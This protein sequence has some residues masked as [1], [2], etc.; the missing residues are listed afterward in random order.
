MARKTDNLVPLPEYPRPLLA[1]DEWV[2]LNGRWRFDYD[3]D[4]SGEDAG[5]HETGDL[6]RSIMVP[7]VHQAPLSG[8]GDPAQVDYVWYAREF[9]VLSSWL[10]DRLV[11]N[12][13]AVDYEATV[14]VNGQ[15]V[16]EHRGGFTPFSCDITAACRPG[17]G[18]LLVVRAFDPITPE[19]PSG[20]QSERESY[21]CM[22]TRSTGIWQTV[23][24]EPLGE[25][26]V[27]VPRI[28]TSLKGAH[29][30]LRVPVTGSAENVYVRVNVQSGGSMLATPEVQPRDGFAEFDI[31]I[32]DPVPWN[33]ETAHLYD[34]RIVTRRGQV[35]TDRASSYFGMRE[36]EVSGD[37][38]L[39][40]GEP[41]VFRGI[42]DQGL[43]P[44]GIYTAPSDLEMRNEISRSLQ[45]GFN[46]ARLHQ[47]VFDPRQLYWAD[48]MGYPVWAE[49]PDWGCHLANPAA[50][51]NLMRE[52][53][54]AVSRDI[55]HP[56]IIIWTPLNE[57]TGESYHSDPVQHDFVR[58]LVRRTKELDSTR[59]VCSTSGYE[60]VTETDIADTHDYRHDPEAL[61]KT[62]TPPFGESGPVTG[63]NHPTFT[64][65]ERYTG[66]PVIVSEMGGMWWDPE[67]AAD[68]EAWGYGD[69]PKSVEDF[70]RIYK[71]IIQVCLECPALSG[72][73]Y[74]QL[75]DVEQ[76]V[77]GLYTYD[78]KPKFDHDA[79]AAIT[80]MP[81]EPKPGG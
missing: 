81:V 12:F 39:L 23:W 34:M 35:V 3:P 9:A 60:H 18:N 58:E 25:A 64:Q 28:I 79:I 33:M 67:K 74:T 55:S 54:E 76:E 1:R 73:V 2:N 5:W 4:G 65:G 47:K 36:V 15:K 70:I 44:D 53:L 51:E 77:N 26:F 22:Y 56:S 57:R 68:T 13:G 29:V 80:R 6:K 50:R 63:H 21:G 43:W 30:K 48:R 27:G 37:R 19:H 66:Q 42:L 40:N 75:T 59:P 20:K 61:R 78:R 24:L 38:V 52:W 45:F 46:S 14:W 62:Y 72:F 49:F 8:I 7:Y 31:R 16:G 71:D 41:L 10:R 69:R 32:P 11:V 17:E